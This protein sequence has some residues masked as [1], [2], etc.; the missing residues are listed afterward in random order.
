LTNGKIAYTDPAVKKTFNTIAD[1]AKRGYFM[2][3]A[4]S[5]SWQEAA[6]VLFRGEAGMYL[7]GQFIMDAA[8][9]ELKSNIDFSDS[10]A[11]GG[12]IIPSILLSMGL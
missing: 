10:P 6:N 4:A 1:M 11:L 2:P 9:A 8:P 12:A 5:Y 3:N 7:M